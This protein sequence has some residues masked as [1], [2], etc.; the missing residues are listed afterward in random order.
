MGKMMLDARKDLKRTGQA[1]R[2]LLLA[3]TSLLAMGTAL[4]SSRAVAAD[5]PPVTG[6]TTGYVMG[7]G[8]NNLVIANTGTISENTVGGGPA[9]KYIAGGHDLLLNQGIITGP[10]RALYL[11]GTGGTGYVTLTTLVNS[12]TIVSSGGNAIE[13]AAGN[14]LVSIVNSGLISGNLLLDGDS[15]VMIFG[16]AGGAIGSFTGVSGSQGTI[17]STLA[18]LTLGGGS[19]LLN[20]AITVGASGTLVNSGASVTLASIVSVTGNY[21]Q[22]DGTL[23]L[24]AGAELVVSGDANVTGGTVNATLSGITSGNTY[25]V[26]Q[27]LATLVA[28][29]SGTYTGL[30]TSFAGGI[31]G[32][33]IGAGTAGGN[34][35]AQATNDYV[36]GTAGSLTLTGTVHTGGTNAYVAGSASIGTLVNAGSLSGG[37]VGLHVQSG[38]HIGTLVNTGLIDVSAGGG[39]TQL[40]IR[41][42]GGSVATLSNTG[43]IIGQF[44]ILSQAVVGLMSNS[45]V[46][47]VTGAGGGL[48]SANPTSIVEN[49]G[50]IIVANSGTAIRG[51]VAINTLINSGLITVGSSSGIGMRLS[52]RQNTVINS[53]TVAAPRA[54][55]MT[56]GGGI[57][58]FVNSGLVAGDVINGD[59]FSVYEDLSIVG[60]TGGTVGTFTGFAANSQGTITSTFSNLV[61]AGG[62]LLLNDSIN[63]IGHTVVNSGASLTLVSIVSVTGDFSQSAGALNLGAN[64]LVVSGT[65]SIGGGVVAA[66]LASLTVG[67]N[68]VAG[69]ALAT[70]V[71]AGSGTYGGMAFAVSSGVSPLVIVQGTDA[72]NLLALAGNDY[73]G[74]T[75]ASVVNTGTIDNLYVAATGSL[76]SFRNEA[77]GLLANGA[78]N[79]GSIGTL[80]NAGTLANG[81]TNLGAI[82]TLDNAG[83]VLV[84][85][86]S[87]FNANG[88]IG[89]LSNSGTISNGG[90]FGLGM[91]VRGTVGLLQNQVGG[92]IGGPFAI[93][94]V[95]PSSNN[96][97]AATVGT[98]SNAGTI[99]GGYLAIET[100]GTVGL[101]QNRTGGTIT[102]GNSGVI[103]VYGGINTLTNGGLIQGAYTGVIVDNAQFINGTIG[104]LQNLADGSIVV[105]SG[106]NLF[107]GAAIINHSRIDT[108]LN[109]GYI[110]AVVSGILSDGTIGTLANQVGGTIAVSGAFGVTWAGVQAGG[111]IGTLSNAGLITIGAYAGSHTGVGVNATGTLGQLSNSGTILGPNGIFVRSG[112]VDTLT[113]QAG[114]TIAAT[115]RGITNVGIIGRLDTQTLSTISGGTTG[116]FNALGGSIGTLANAGVIA[117][118][119]AN[120]GLANQGQIDLL[121]NSGTITGSIGIHNLGQ[122][123]SALSTIGTLINSGLIRGTIGIYEQFGGGTLVSNSGTILGANYGI[124]ANASTLGTIANSGLITATGRGIQVS[125][126]ATIG[127]L[128]NQAL[129]TITAGATAILNTVGGSIGTLANAGLIAGGA[130]SDG[131][132]NKGQIDLLDNSGTITGSI[133]IHNQSQNFPT[134]GTIGTLVNSGLIRGTIGIYEE[135]GGGTLISNSGTILGGVYGIGAYWGTL[136]TIANGG[137]LAFAG[138]GTPVAG[139][140]GA[141]STIG[142]ITNSGTITGWAAGIRA[143]Q[144]GATIGTVINSGVIATTRD[145]IQAN[146]GATIGALLN[147]GAITAPTA[148]Q[149]TG[150]ARIGTLVNSGLIAGTVQNGNPSFGDTIAGD[151]TIAGGTGGTVG[152]FTGQTLANKGLI[153]NRLSNLT[154]TGGSLLL[155]D[156]INA[157]SHLVS[158]QAA[159]IALNSI[160]TVT[161]DYSQSAAG[162]LVL[163]GGGLTVSGGATVAGVIQATAGGSATANYLVGD[164]VA[165]LLAAGTLSDTADLTL[166][167]AALGSHLAVTS[168]TATNALLAL[169]T[170]DYI[171]AGYGTI[172]VGS[173]TLLSGPTALY[174]ASSGSL[175]ALANSG[176]IAGAITNLSA[177]DLTILGGTGAATGT[178]TGGSLTNQGT[179]TSTLANVVLAGGRLL[180]NDTV[181][182]GTGTLINSGANL[183][184]ATLVSVGGAYSQATGVLSVGG[185]GTLAVS[186][187]ASITGGDLVATR[188]LSATGNYLAGTILDTLVTGGA[189]SRYD[190]V[191]VTNYSAAIGGVGGIVVGDNLLLGAT[192]NY[193]GGTYGSLANT[194]TL[195][196]TFGVLVGSLGTLDTFSNSGL[197][198]LTGSTRIGVYDRSGTIGVVDNSGT[199]VARNGVQVDTGGTVGTIANSGTITAAASGIELYNAQ[200]GLI[201]NTGTIGGTAVFATGINLLQGARAETIANAGLIT[202]TGY[203]GNGIVNYAGSTIGAVL[204]SGT[205]VAGGMGV[206]N[207]ASIASI[208]TLINSGVIS[209]G[210]GAIMNTDAGTIGV[211]INTGTLLNSSNSGYALANHNGAV[212]GTLINAGVIAGTVTGALYASDTIGTD[213]T[214]Q[215]GDNG[216][217]GT[218]TSGNMLAKGMIS[219]TMGNVT[220]TSGALL[221]HD[222]IY[223]PNYSVTNIAAALTLDTPV[224]ITGAYNQLGG[225]LAMGTA[226]GLSVTGAAGLAGQYQAT[227]TG[228]AAANYMV[229]DTAGTLVQADGGVTYSGS[230]TGATALDGHLQLR[231]GTTSNQLLALA[232]TDYIGAGYGTIT[233][234]SGTLLSGPTA[235]YIASTG[236]LGALANSGT[237]AGAITNDSA[238]DLTILGGT[239]AATGTLTGGSLTNQGTITN[240]LANVV[241]AGGSLLLNDTVNV[242]TG[243]LANTG[244]AVSLTTVVN[245]TGNYSQAT[246]TLA[247][248]TGAELVV[249]GA[250]TISGGTVAAAALSDTGNYLVGSIYGTLVAGGAGSSYTG[251]TVIGSN[252]PGM[253]STVAG[254]NLA[255]FATGNYIGASYGS[256]S[257]SGTLAGAVALQVGGTGSLGTFSNSGLV[258]GAY[259]PILNYNTLGLLENQ[260]GGTI[261]V[262]AAG[263]LHQDTAAIYNGQ[264]AS[265]GAITNAGVIAVANA[266]GDLSVYGIYAIVNNGGTVG[267]ITNT[268]TI[269]GRAG[270]FSANSGSNVIGTIDNRGL[271]SGRSDISLQFTRATLVTNSGTLTGVGNAS[272]SLLTGYF[273]T[274]GT[275]VNNGLMAADHGGGGI[276]NSYGSIGTVLNQGTIRVSGSG[277]AISSYNAMIGTVVNSGA[278]LTGGQ[279]IAIVGQYGAVLGTLVNTGTISARTALRFYGNSSLGGIVNSGLIQGTIMNGDAT[280][281]WTGQVDTVVSNLTLRGGTGTT[282]GTFAGLTGKGL[283]DN[284]TG[285]LTFA[286]GNLLL[287]DDILATGHSAI[288]SAA[289]LTLGS[290]ITVTGTYVQG[291]GALVIGNA[292]T[293]QADS[294]TVTGGQVGLDGLGNY[295]VGQAQTVI[296]ATSGAYSGATLNGTIGTGSAIVLGTLVQSGGALLAQFSSDYVGGS[297]VTLTNSGTITSAFPGIAVATTG[298]V[299]TLTNAGAVIGTQQAVVLSGIVDTLVNTGTVSAVTAI[300]LSGTV[301]SVLNTGVVRGAV[302]LFG[303]ST[304]RFTNTGTITG[305]YNSLVGISY[306]GLMAASSIG[307]LVN[308]GTINAQYALLM[309]GAQGSNS[310]GTLINSGVIAGNLVNG[311][312]GV[313]GFLPSDTVAGDLTIQG[314]GNGA[315]GTFTGQAAKGL[316]QNKLSNLVFSGG[317]LLLNDDVDVT[318][319]TALNSGASL[320]LTS[321]IDVT[322][323]YVQ[324]SAGTLVVGKGGQMAVD[325]RA[326]IAGQLRAGVATDNFLPGQQATLVTGSVGSDYSAATIA[327]N[328]AHLTLTNT[329]ANS[330]V[331]VTAQNYYIGGSL[332]ADITN[333]GTVTAATAVYI[334]GGAT[335]VGTLVNS[336]VIAGDVIDD[337][338]GASLMLAG[339][340]SIG[341]FTGGTI[342]HTQGDIHITQGTIR[343]NDSVNAGT[344]TLSIDSPALVTLG[345]A[346]AVTGTLRMAGGLLIGTNP[347]LLTAD[348]ATLTGRVLTDARGNYLAGDT[349]TL[350]QAA[351]ADYSAATLASLTGFSGSVAQQGGALVVHYL[352]DYVGAGLASLDNTG[353]LGGSGYGVY[354]ASTGSI[355][356]L[357]NSGALGGLAAGVANAGGTIGTLV[358]TGTIN[359]AYAL[360]LGG[361]G[362]IGTLVNSG[363]IAGTLV[364]GDNNLVGLGVDTVAANLSIQGGA[365]T[366]VGTFTGQNLTGKGSILNRLSDL[367]FTGGKLW[368]NDDINVG[369]HTV[370]NLG[371]DVTLTNAVTITGAYTQAAGGILR[372]GGGAHLTVTG[373][374][375][376]GGTV[377]AGLATDT[378]TLGQVETLIAGGSGSDFGAAQVTGVTGMAVFGGVSSNAFGDTALVG[379]HTNYYIGGSLGT[380]SNSGNIGA[381]TIVYIA[382]TG[383]LG[384]L[385]NS[386]T[387]AGNIVNRSARALSISGGTGG[388][389]G[390]FTGGTITNTASDL[391]LVGGDLSMADAI[392]VTGHTLVNS[393]ANVTL[394]GTIAVSGDYSQTAGSLVI[395]PASG[396]LNVSG[397]ASLT[398]GTVAMAGF[399]VTGNYFAGTLGTLVHA[400]G[401]LTGGAAVTAAGVGNLNIASSIIGGD[402]LALIG[403]DYIGGTLGSLANIDTISSQTALYVATTGS[404]GSLA[405]NGTLT[406]Q[407]AGLSNDGTIG[408]LVN[409]ATIN[410]RGGTF[411][412]AIGASVGLRNTGVIGGLSNSGMIS[413]ANTGLYNIASIGTLANSGILTAGN[414]AFRNSSSQGVGG[415][416]DTLVN[417]GLVSGRV[418]AVVVNA[419]IIGLL[420]NSGT[421]SA[422]ISAVGVNGGTIGTLRNSGTITGDVGAVAVSNLGSIA[423]ILNSGL[424]SSTGNALTIRNNATLGLLIN[425]GVIAGSIRNSSANT[426][427]IQGGDTLAGTFT[428]LNG[429]RGQI[430]NTA[431][432]VVFSAGTLL[433][434]DDITATGHAVRNTGATITLAAATSISGDYG[435]SGGILAL[436]ATSTLGASGTISI[437]GGA[438]Q[439]NNLSAMAN[440]LHP[441]LGVLMTGAAASDYSGAQYLSGVDGLAVGGVAANGTLTGLVLNDYIGTTYATLG[442]SGTVQV[443]GGMAQ[444]YVAASGSLGGYTNTGSLSGGGSD[445]LHVAGTIGT[446]SN[447]GVLTAASQA[448]HVAGGTVGVLSNIGT[449]AGNAWGLSNQGGIGSLSNTGWIG[450]LADSGSIGT[451]DNAGSITEVDVSGQVQSLLN[452]GRIGG[453]ANGIYLAQGGTIANLSITAAGVLAGTQLGIQSEERIGTLVNAGLIQ[454]VDAGI[455]NRRGTSTID[456]LNNQGTIWAT[457]SSGIAINN[458]GTIGTLVNSGAITAAFPLGTGIGG[459]GIG[460]VTVTGSGR[461]TGARGIVAESMNTLANSGTIV[462][463]TIGVLADGVLDTLLNDG[464]IA[465]GTF[466]GTL[467][468]GQGVVFNNDFTL[469]RN[470]GTITGGYVGVGAFGTH[471]TV[472]NQGS[473]VSAHAAIS[474]NGLDVLTNSGLISGG[475]GAVSSNNGVAS[476]VNSGTIAGGTVA[477]SGAFGGIDNSGLIQG[478]VAAQFTG[479]VTGFGNSGVVAGD[480]VATIGDLSITGGSGTHVGTFT[481]YAA[482]TMGTI[483]VTG[484]NLVLAGGNLLLNDQV[485]GSVV[486]GAAAVAIG[487]AV[488]VTGAYT[489]AAG[490][491]LQVNSANPLL[492]TGQATVAGG[493]VVGQG[494][495]NFTVSQATTLVSAAAGSNYSAATVGGLAGMNV[496]GTVDG[497]GRLIATFQ[498]DY[499]GASL[500]TLTNTGSISANTAVY[501][502]GTGSLGTLV[503]SG[504]LSGTLAAVSI[505]VGGVLDVLDN[506]QTVDGNVINAGSHVLTIVGNSS[507]AS[508]F[509][510]GTIRSRAADMV[511]AAG[512]LSLGDVVDVGAQTLRNTGATI[513]SN[514][515]LNVL[516]NYRQTAGELDVVATSGAARASGNIDL[517]GGQVT[518]YAGNANILA[519]DVSTIAQ[520]GGT[521]GVSGATIQGWNLSIT[522]AVSGGNLL[523]TAHTDYLGASTT[524]VV[525]SAAIDGTA[526][527]AYVATSATIGTVTNQGTLSAR[528][529]TAVQ[530]N[531]TIGTLV[532]TGLIAGQDGAL[533]ITGRLDTL[534]NAGVIAG[535]ITNATSHAL[536]IAGGGTGTVG[537]VA[538]YA[539]GMRGTINNTLGSLTFAAGNLLV[540]DDINAAGQT[541]TNSGG[542]L[543]LGNGAITG[544][545]VQTG[546]TLSIMSLA[547]SDAVSLTGGVLVA[548]GVTA[549]GNYLAST[550]GTLV[551]AGAASSYAGVTLASDLTGLNVVGQTVGNDL[552]VV[553]NNDYIGGT[554]ATLTNSG[555]LSAVT[556]VYIAG[557]GSLG[558][559]VNSGTLSGGITN[560]SAH[561]L[562]IAG[563]TAGGLGLLTG[564][565]IRNTQSDLTFTEGALRLEDAIDVTGHTVVNSGA[566]LVIGGTVAVAGNF[567]QTG[568]SLLLDLYG[569]RLAV[570]GS[571][572]LTGGDLTITGASNLANYT[573]G[574][575]LSTLVSGGAGANYTGLSI[576]TDLT[577]FN[578][579]SSIAGNALVAVAFSDY[580][581]GTLGTL[582][583]T[584]TITGVM[585]GLYVAGT[586]SLGTFTN[587]GA[588]AAS[589]RAVAISPYGTAGRVDT[590]VNRGDITGRTAVF[591][592]IGGRVGTL[593]NSG[594]LAGTG[595]AAVNNFAGSIGLVQNSG[596]IASSYP[597]SALAN[598]WGAV[599]GTVSNTGV[600]QG[601]YNGGTIGLVSIGTAG[602]MHGWFTG[603]VDAGTLAAVINDGQIS[604]PTGVRVGGSNGNAGG[605]SMGTLTN[606]GTI[607][608]TSRGIDNMVSGAL[609]PTIAWLD[610]TGLITSANGAAIFNEGSAGALGTLGTLANSGTIQGVVGLANDGTLGALLNSGTLAGSA[611]ALTIGALG[612]L[613]YF[614]NDGLVAG[615]IVN[616]AARDLTINNAGSTGTFG[617][618]T[619]TGYGASIQGTIRN[620]GG[621]VVFASGV[622]TLNDAIDVGSHTVVNSGIALTLAGSIS[623]TGDYAEA[624]GTVTMAPGNQLAVSGVASINGAVFSL[625]GQTATGNYLAGT[626]G[627]VVAGGA[628]SDY[629][630][631][632]LTAGYQGVAA[633]S[634]GGNLMAVATSD[635]IGGS[636]ASAGNSDTIV[637]SLASSFLTVAG[638]GTLGSFTNSGRL[639]GGVFQVDVAGV[640][641]TFVNTGSLSGNSLA[642]HIDTIGSVGTLSNSGVIGTA[643]NQVGIAGTLGLLSNS[644]AMGGVSVGGTG[645]LGT[646]DNSGRLSSVLVALGGHLDSLVNTGWM[647]SLGA[648]GLV[649][650]ISNGGTIS[651]GPTGINLTQASIGSL[652]NTGT[653]S[654]GVAVAVDGSSTIGILDNA[655]SITEVD[656]SG[657]VLSLLNSGSIGGNA[658]GIYLAQGGTID[659]LSIGAGGVLAGTQL[660]LQSEERIGALTNDGLVQGASTGINN[661]RTNSTIDLLNNRGTIWATGSTGFAIDN[662]G[663][664]GTLLN[665]GVIRAEA[666]MGTGVGGNGRIGLLSITGSGQVIGARGVDAGTV[667]TLANS[668]LI[669]GGT[670]GVHVNGGVDTLVNAG[671]I[672]GGT[673]TA[674]MTAGQGVVY[675][676]A[677]GLLRNSGTIS[678]GYA[679]VSAGGTTGTILNS[680]SIL[681]RFGAVSINGLDLLNNSGLL[682][683]G[684]AVFSNSGIGSLVNTGTV[685]GGTVALSGAFGVI[686]NAG[687]IQGPV[688]A[689]FSNQVAGFTNSGIV[690]GDIVATIGDLSITGGSGTNVGTFTGYAANTQGTITV[691]GGNL[692]FAGGGLWLNDQVA[693]SVVNAGSDLILTSIVS[694]SGAYS[695][696]SGTL[697]LSRGAGQ[698]VVADAASITGGTVVASVSAGATY[699]AGTLGTLV[700]GG[701]GSTYTGA[702]IV[703]AVTGLA[704]SGLTA[705][706]D[707]L[708]MVDNDYIGGTLATLTNSGAIAAATALYIAT[709]G[710]LGTL[711]NSGTLTGN[712]RNLTAHDLVVVGGP[713]GGAVGTLAGGTIVN[714]LSGVSFIAGDLLLADAINVGGNTVVNSGANLTIGGT[715]AVTGNYSQTGGRLIL[716][717]GGSQ[718]A[719][720]GSAALTGGVV[721][722]TGASG[723]ANYTVGS[724]LATLVSGGAGSSYT[725]SITNDLTGFDIGSTVAGNALLA[726]AHSDYIGGSLGSLVNTGTVSAATALRIASTGSLGSFAN[727]GVLL[728]GVDAVSNLGTLGTLY[729][730][731]LITGTTAGVANSG[732]LGLLLNAATGT[733]AGGIANQG[734]LGRLA[735]AGLVTGATAIANS[736]A[737]TIATVANTGLIQGGQVG[738][739]NAATIGLLDNSGT[740]SG[741]TA[742]R[743]AAGGSVGS[744][745]NSG[746]IQGDIVNLAA[747]GLTI[748]GG[749]GTQVGTLAGGTITGTGTDVAFNAGTLLLADAVNVAGHTLVNSGAALVLNS[750]VSVTGNY[751]QTGGV[752]GLTAGSGGLA[753]SGAATLSGGVVAAA[754]DAGVNY[755]GGSIATLVSAAGGLS[756]SASI[757]NTVTGL[758]MVTRLSGTDLTASIANDYIGGTL[759]SLT[760]T[761]ALGGPT[762]FYVAAAGSIGTLVNNGTL[763]GTLNGLAVAGGHIDQISNTSLIRGSSTAGV[764]VAAGGRLDTLS[765]S[766][767]IAS[768]LGVGALVRG[769]L[770]SLTNGGQMTGGAAAV[771][772]GS[773]G[774]VGTVSNMAGGTLAAGTA[775]V[776]VALGGTLGGF[777]NAGVLT[778]ARLADIAGRV[779]LIGNSGTLTGG[780]STA[781]RVSGTLGTLANSGMITAAH[782][783]VSITSSGVLGLLANSGTIIGD[784]TNAGAQD[785]TITGGG[786][787]AGTFTGGTLTNLA[788]NVVLAGGGLAFN[789]TVNVTGHTLVNS[790]ANVLLSSTLTITGAYSQTG[791]TLALAGNHLVVSGVASLSGGTVSTSIA[792]A[793]NVN[794][795]RGD[796]LGTLVIGGA[797]S[798]YTGV[799]TQVNVTGLGAAASAVTIGAATDLVATVSNNYIGGT[800]S[801]LSNAGTIV[802]VTALYVGSGGSVGSVSNSGALSGSVAGVVNNG[803]VGTLTNSGTVT[804]SIAGIA[805][806]GSVGSFSND[807]S[808]GGSIAGV[809]NSGTIGTLGNTGT[810]TGTVTG[811]GNQ[812][813]ASIGTLSNSGTVAGQMALNN[814]GT[815]E[816]VV[817]NGALIDAGAPTAAGLYNTGAIA[818]VLNGGTILGATYGVYNAGTIGTLANSG[819]ITAPTALYIDTGASLGVLVNSG[820]VTGN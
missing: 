764:Q 92:S 577:G 79:L 361:G 472:D 492:V 651:G 603:L 153:D 338:A 421:V 574:S 737:G 643:G 72:G 15:A 298:S 700:A 475:S 268:G 640:I 28:A 111:S 81:V 670:I 474:V 662:A 456:L 558:T 688:A 259:R 478:P 105:S 131:L 572:A 657:R 48:V 127:T 522:S 109:S 470:T 197:M 601:L 159:T 420:D 312:T 720:S 161:G 521:L 141:Y 501:V 424:I 340:A 138:A 686:D 175:G 513:L 773:G 815:I 433:L 529:N 56:N 265:I 13:I 217:V 609:S 408:T 804:G 366:L 171:G 809:S 426:L 428:G 728:G 223:V 355:G 704:S 733:V 719:V 709:S 432:D 430:V 514:A 722:I 442:N 402:L 802:A 98:L 343:L 45:G 196:G 143:D 782:G 232:T 568:G 250:A 35:V 245:V 289:A 331:V 523:V 210:T 644:G 351:T 749:N 721:T 582:N 360:G 60:G 508:A 261:T 145:G 452:S 258:T 225:T 550:L 306:A 383:T 806:A 694:I 660:G 190:G 82:G 652:S 625:T 717:L 659:S 401:T 698:L 169:A 444:L 636:L 461:V 467:I 248:A 682:S 731:N 392:D 237:I 346:V 774:T 560:A 755:F 486:N 5:P 233:V 174:I 385:S 729:N 673:L 484:G 129:G 86:S 187:A 313:L 449:L 814:A 404:I 805:N 29:N 537:T 794:Y 645:T 415:T 305:A 396:E 395:Q 125:G 525:S 84:S 586:G 665:S 22:S 231:D 282:V 236:S 590:L 469:L 819:L 765:N 246:G 173:G 762:A 107:N 121:D 316:I 703:T 570:S 776:L 277:T 287:N 512:R 8:A 699:L 166:N 32:L 648:G 368:L 447:S 314:G 427:S 68:Y 672:Q 641:G 49:S 106:T 738:L 293:L 345:G 239:G 389:V 791:G 786:T 34:L 334:A 481:G 684:S 119:A 711:V 817:N 130:S 747:G 1:S 654:A 746:L 663:T 400:G 515:P 291:G 624:G 254:N 715:V 58:Y 756:V 264:L 177:N 136:G 348:S 83:L 134:L 87:G 359:A 480:I 295:V 18:N 300:G 33:S 252:I 357:S 179:I 272:V 386:G 631:T 787:V 412:N 228:D 235:L 382:G 714:S 789:D 215:G 374:G 88:T 416:I 554:L 202:E 473:I 707:L 732:V 418:G 690:A 142:L 363:V 713:G 55:V 320:T 634:T 124:V 342:T 31:G 744:I 220:F 307:T 693:G 730:A 94:V 414:F 797:G 649:A 518:V 135:F 137:T 759:D 271:I 500:P 260:A 376:V 110:G 95:G 21:G 75:L 140:Y 496:A 638:T 251:A 381:G 800:L 489:Q 370:S 696:A 52:A 318:G 741:I 681:S 182:V 436:N 611:A 422:V 40:G 578:I 742:L 734:V 205:I 274:I 147:S 505:A 23:A 680:G 417:A 263:T 168:G 723:L 626:L 458:Q 767:I 617:G 462:G 394:G 181:N 812:A 43:T 375:T 632:S 133:G 27:T 614:Q 775:A 589:G 403:N 610:N 692:V 552:L 519:G 188:A 587:T 580:I 226:G 65:A 547:V 517:A 276:S 743:V 591:V 409:A 216:T 562:A 710:N 597:Y 801:T 446:V 112:T 650:L 592:G 221:L 2:T 201:T 666:P 241:L 419:G 434:N 283:I 528:S 339:G 405:N 61:F 194:G 379:F 463:Y 708:L 309:A 548:Q 290:A 132:R 653:I 327:S 67:G 286:S 267:Q 117:G 214:I 57:S 324:G 242:G 317:S 301:G 89:T 322:G 3:G 266:P 495:A 209:G 240:T 716:S 520:A 779:A 238:N 771:E 569:S 399:S 303:D 527:A 510:N 598:N 128:E 453:N 353:T 630:G 504:R 606:A 531:G 212:I 612:T 735:N 629:S 697:D 509:Q 542:T 297:L 9:L 113:N 581:G 126:Q 410:Q 14:T 777:S 387:I 661:R 281:A 204:N 213:F 167:A 488:T 30:A 115:H 485:A 373:A 206:L 162:T 532:N 294:A 745:I 429:D 655:G 596:T 19:L 278:I 511:L 628:G 391:A 149:L 384:L 807:G 103:K 664:I 566:N 11:D 47:T 219:N 810:V 778:G 165:T 369:G 770:G 337:R 766:G 180:L 36:G 199:V 435:Q 302:A 752:L 483:T 222:D 380:L 555:S 691:T 718:L 54:L 37:E 443:A 319:H 627:T 674:G 200:A 750:V 6:G 183:T 164:T 493:V 406:G 349:S 288:N 658:N 44:G 70:L 516:G 99:A 425:S 563:N 646:V 785:L 257:N 120:D 781:F 195:T 656:V 354:V 639:T 170:S 229:G 608:G 296:S 808:V 356:T 407:Y 571:V 524:S 678:G 423:T 4:T 450:G 155:N 341:T 20:D 51:P 544:A 325:G 269:T 10:T 185:S 321:T 431:S 540:N 332:G 564:G 503:N 642:V 191:T 253:G 739:L 464:T 64:G 497:N 679:G 42:D 326:T 445:L 595:Y 262:T 393:G 207:Y 803:T 675:D 367:A 499:I 726:V 100:D 146:G 667:G 468:G 26:G 588:I 160:I 397:N 553:A 790:G 761:A 24:G 605:G 63:A 441:T 85:G 139:V 362:T 561:A 273:A 585:T 172:T 818:T 740:L 541:V 71:A 465:G 705:G 151:L 256:L 602:I 186:G 439:V 757:T 539:G 576:T 579:G 284:R 365:G 275:V 479:A 754:Y 792:A 622:L 551:A 668:G 96:G 451:L 192:G 619:F 758:A 471:G 157:G 176:T 599:I 77:T 455:N 329:I 637:S 769:T 336:G 311:N 388:A 820:T 150:D 798:S 364:N 97:T 38:A 371:A 53:G 184:L 108:L 76:G 526:V 535:D 795:L 377:F 39:F 559:L 460:L 751:S 477:L 224:T 350:I 793:T 557:T 227:L 69:D 669:D 753:V 378:A 604:G 799:F 116:V 12:G 594:T 618:G 122:N 234:G 506:E 244:A 727:S 156:D 736:G 249:S 411:S 218:F 158:N 308:S 154:V 621:N 459:G 335:A 448:L 118:G 310:I 545:F 347:N 74:G 701:A 584:G 494:A 695:Q 454:G 772:V 390:S 702:T 671:T 189:G 635:Y 536:V 270:I 437:G 208:G 685:V 613:G 230:L 78:T 507:Q 565:T 573:V 647:G 534:A 491:A 813:G 299:G 203:G 633:I 413:A 607:S 328:L 748:S 490:G 285:D 247:L 198:S 73:I 502:A 549:T 17:T 148:I 546:G 279:A 712:I 59:N 90:G 615:D 280:G 780:A 330:A 62:D 163:N 41:V 783:V 788:S 243:T 556:A 816:V 784:I 811:L 498:N 487:S 211:L 25:L 567:S 50:T 593:A 352:N 123:S 482:N 543:T 676:N 193:I 358:N 760:N 66:S 144:A 623:I 114:G 689:R 93:L 683:G 476:L 466:G 538:G 533:S 101:L 583:N 323:T 768:D 292:N 104:L 457:G 600:L 102:G 91:L 46:I 796:I 315:V 80:D 438:V 677:I 304:T 620:T 7:G 178:L 530:L 152:T 440:Y 333:T 398:G 372:V 255:L 344:G 16:G 724:A 706:G 725:L 687:L 763:A 616:L 575:A